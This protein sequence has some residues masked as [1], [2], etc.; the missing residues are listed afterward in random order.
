[1][2]P[3]RAWPAQVPKEL[4]IKMYETISAAAARKSF[5]LVM[6]IRFLA[7]AAGKIDKV[8]RFKHVNC[9]RVRGEFIYIYLYILEQRHESVDLLNNS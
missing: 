2:S 3:E 9:G 7:R 1:M 4:R 8:Y 6:A 5:H